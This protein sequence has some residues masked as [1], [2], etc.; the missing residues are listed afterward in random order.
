M[1]SGF[2]L[3][4]IFGSWLTPLRLNLTRSVRGTNSDVPT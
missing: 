3:G 1:V 2:S 4:A